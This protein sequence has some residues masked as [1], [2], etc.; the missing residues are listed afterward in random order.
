MKLHI[1]HNNKMYRVDTQKPMCIS[2]T[3]QRGGGSPNA[4]NLP[5]PSI[6]PFAGDNF[7]LSVA[8][9][10][11]VNCETLLLAPHGNGTHTEC[12]GHISKEL[13]YIKDVL[14]EWLFIAQVISIKPNQVDNDFLITK[15]QV[16]NS[17][18]FP[19]ASTL[20]IRTLPNTPEK[21][22]RNWS[23]TNPVYLESDVM[24]LCVELGVKHL[25]VD[26]PSVDKEEDGGMLQAHHAFW[27]YPE[28]PRLDSTITE[29]AYIPNHIPDGTYLLQF[30]VLDIESDASP[31]KIVLY[32][33][34]QE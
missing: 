26:F 18:T 24:L 25:V 22:S 16:K 33:L 7:V 20:V 10:A 21:L 30:N 14:K 13:V 11:P 23:G 34:E 2:T 5:A 32:N 6:Q 29:M 27:N 8:R 12:V 31:S 28:S 9:G 4:Y 3:L 19:V 15:E 1:E 17:I